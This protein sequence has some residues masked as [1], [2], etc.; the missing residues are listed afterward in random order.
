[1]YNQ[2]T[3]TYQKTTQ[4]TANPRE[5]E[6][7]LLLK[8]ARKL[9]AVKESWTEDNSGLNE[10]LDFN[11]RLWSI[12]ATS[13]TAPESPLPREIK[14]NIGNLAVFIFR[15]TLSISRRS[16]PTRLN[17]LIQINKVMAEG[18]RGTA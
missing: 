8:A 12:L 14:Q 6:A 7:S 4:S 18:L 3:A 9:Q 17:S 11:R 15:H 13:A 2:A 10:A 1:M 16:E 5:L